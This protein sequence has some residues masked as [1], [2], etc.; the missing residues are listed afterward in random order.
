MK[1]NSESRLIETLNETLGP[2]DHFVAKTEIEE[3]LALVRNRQYIIRSLVEAVNFNSIRKIIPI[4][5]QTGQGK[6]FVCWKIKQNLDI[7]A[8]VLF[9]DV[10]TNPKLFFYD[11]YTNMI[12][13]LCADSLDTDNRGADILRDVT[14]QISDRWGANEMKYGLFRTDNT[15]KILEQ[16]RDTMR[17]KW[18]KHK[19]ELQDCMKVIIAHAMDPEKFG[20]AE[21]WMLGEIMDPDELFYLGIHRNL[22]AP[23]VAEEMLKILT[24]YIEE[25][26][27]LLYDDIDINWSQFS[28]AETWEAD[29]AD[30]GVIEK[31]GKDSIRAEKNFFGMIIYVMKYTRRLKIVMTMSTENK[32]MVLDHFPDT[33]KLL[34][35][36]TIPLMNFSSQDTKEFYLDVMREY[37][38]KNNISNLENPYFPLSEKI[39]IY[40]FRKTKGN[41]REI[42]REVQKLFDLVIFDEY[43]TEMLEKEYLLK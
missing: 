36:H 25:G 22:S 37:R 26:F 6:T 9:M 31:D 12:N 32:Q 2:F 19:E 30:G 43:S 8:N 20:L 16:A 10:P 35:H 23:Y 15:Q 38:S 17:Y 39:L 21:R 3:T 27:V 24:E 4:T 14:R 40:I 13:C 34:I 29:W 5:G 1:N 33:M 18:S 41:P 7:T 11:L 42:I 28:G